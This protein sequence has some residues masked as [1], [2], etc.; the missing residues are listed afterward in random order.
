MPIS[1]F[2]CEDVNESCDRGR[3]QHN[4]Y[5]DEAWVLISRDEPEHLPSI[6][7]R[8]ECQQRVPDNSTQRKG[9]DKTFRGIFHRARGEKKWNQGSWRR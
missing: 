4:N 3:D 2:C 1:T 7:R 9:E 5:Y 8:Q 6:A